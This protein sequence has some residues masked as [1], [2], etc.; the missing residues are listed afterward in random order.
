M[1]CQTLVLFQLWLQDMAVNIPTA[2]LTHVYA[3][4]FPLDTEVFFTNK[5]QLPI[6]FAHHEPSQTV[7]IRPRL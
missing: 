2:Y 5:Q 6:D 3:E 7:T 4:K 1:D